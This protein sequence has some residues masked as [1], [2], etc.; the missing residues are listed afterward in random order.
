MGGL[1]DEHV[2]YLPNRA[3]DEDEPR[4]IIRV[5][6]ERGHES[7]ARALQTH[8]VRHEEC[9]RSRAPFPLFFLSV[10]TR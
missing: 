1:K 2:R 5:L 7:W 3:D 9:G 10:T 6:L 4:R 8:F